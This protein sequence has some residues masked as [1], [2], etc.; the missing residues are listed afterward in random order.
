[1]GTCGEHVQLVSETGIPREG[2]GKLNR[3]YPSGSV[4]PKSAFL[5]GARAKSLISNSSS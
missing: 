2:Q 1:V 4:N 5:G 3:M